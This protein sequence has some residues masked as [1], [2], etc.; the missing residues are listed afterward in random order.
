M[1][2]TV[3]NAQASSMILLILRWGDSKTVLDVW[4]WRLETAST[5]GRM[6]VEIITASMC[7]AISS[8]VHTAKAINKP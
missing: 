2:K 7:T 1:P 5:W 6:Q 8:T 4:R 3:L